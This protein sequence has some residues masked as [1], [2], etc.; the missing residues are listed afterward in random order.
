MTVANAYWEKIL[1]EKVGQCHNCN[2]CIPIGQRKK[3]DRISD[4]RFDTKE[5]CCHTRS[6]TTGCPVAIKVKELRERI[7]NQ[8]GNC[9]REGLR[10]CMY[11]GYPEDTIPKSC[12]YKIGDAAVN[13]VYD[14]PILL[15]KKV[16]KK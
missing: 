16:K 5:K 4:G 14:V 13:T 9:I 6:S 12:A 7:E 10:D 1:S 8:C 3:P 11:H 2:N 15:Q